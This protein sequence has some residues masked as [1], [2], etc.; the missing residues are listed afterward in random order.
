M[1]VAQSTIDSNVRMAEAKVAIL[2]TVRAKAPDLTT[3]EW[4]CVLA[5]LMRDRVYYRLRA[6]RE[7]AED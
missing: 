3:A 2:E 5:E 7:T 4:E 1:R 6:E